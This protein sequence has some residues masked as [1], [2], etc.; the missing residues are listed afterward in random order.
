MKYKT[1]IFDLDGTLIDPAVGAVRCMNYALTSLDYMARPA[2]EITAL[3][4]PPLEYALQALSGEEDE[5]KIQRLVDA[6]RERY[7]EF[8]ISENTVYPG[9]VDL[10][11][12]LTGKGIAMGVC[13]SKLEKNAL[14]ILNKYNLIDYFGFVSGA[15]GATFKERKADQLAGLLSARSIDTSA[16]MIG[17]RAIDIEAAAENSLSGCG[18]LWGYGARDE[19]ENAQPALLISEPAQLIQV[20]EV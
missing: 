7:A 20:L 19:L 2:H 9:I 12:E 8:G 5:V 14:K 1:L 10:L 13:T 15:S 16:L 4:G 18:V 11:E 3:I 6:Y 17:D